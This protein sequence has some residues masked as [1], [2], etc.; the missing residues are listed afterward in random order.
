MSDFELS[1]LSWNKPTVTWFYTGSK[2][3]GS[4]PSF[5]TE[6]S[7]AFAKWDSVINLDFQEVS[8]QAEADI[9]LTFGP[10]DGAFGTVGQALSIFSGS[11]YVN[12]QTITFDSAEPWAFSSAADSFTF[13]GSTNSTTFY[14]VALHEIGHTLG[15]DHPTNPN[16]ILSSVILPGVADLTDADIA[17]ARVL[18]GAESALPDLD[19]A[20]AL[21]LSAPAVQQGSDVTISYTVQNTGDSPAGASTAGIY[22]S[23][24]STIT[25]GDTLLTSVGVGALG[26]NGSTSESVSIATNGIAPG[27]YFLGIIPDR[28]NVIVESN[29]NNNASAGI[30]FSVTTN[31]I[32]SLTA[33]Q[34]GEVAKL[35]LAYFN[36]APEANG[37]SFHIDAALADLNAGSSFDNALTKRADQFFDAA[38]AQP[39][40]SGYSD[41]Q[42][43][44]DF[45][46]TIYSNVL[47][48][49]GSGGDAPST[50]D[51]D[52]WVNRV[53][54]G[55]ITRGQ[56][57]TEFLKAVDDLKAN[58][59]AAEQAIA[60]QI[61]QVLQN[62]LTVALEF[63]KAENSGSLTGEAAFNAGKAILDGVDETQ[64]SVDAAFVSLAA[65]S[66]S[67]STHVVTIAFDFTANAQVA[68]TSIDVV[69]T[70]L[71]PIEP[72]A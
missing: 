48:R 12:Q 34:Q 57:V 72:I 49:P 9:A 24:D 35:Y 41:S 65:S 25:T 15:L 4:E 23:S 26:A 22:L 21:Q 20:T 18:Y 5:Y 54:N 59:T 64:A 58:G 40:F 53:S 69:G 46:S 45:V 63:A 61:D 36:R 8:T 67:S 6:I 1:G 44:G 47:L 68:D 60:N 27:D 52:Y 71:D 33:E 29:E 13:N 50:S 19:I 11:H 14:A 3:A 32:A 17:G 56:V 31:A 37:L 7:E 2:P 16:V 70:A 51:I 43:L 28:D 55:E 10:I 30:S 42:P 39:Q 38:I 66:T 62:R